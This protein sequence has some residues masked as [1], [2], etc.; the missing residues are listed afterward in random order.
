V[1]VDHA[2]V[3]PK[4]A[5]KVGWTVSALL[6]AAY[7]VVFAGYSAFSLQDYPN[8]LARAVAMSD[9]MFHGGA[10]F[11]ELFQYHFSAVPY[12]LGDL[13]L[14]GAI[15]LFGAR[16][17]SE[18][19]IALVM[20]SLPLALLFYLRGSRLAPDSRVLVFILS[21]YLS[22]DGFL[23]MGFLNFR[24]GVAMT[25]V[26]FAM[27]QILRQRW[28]TLLFAAYCVIVGLC[29]LMHLST[30]VFLGAAIGISALLRLWLRSTK[31]RNEAYFF[32]PVVAVLAWHFGVAIAHHAATDL[33]QNTFNWGTWSGKI[34]RLHWDF[35]RYYGTRL[36]RRVDEFLLLGFAV[37]LLWPIRH[38][39]G[40][41]AL[42]K[43]AVL[44]M[45]LLGMAFVGIYIVLPFTGSDVA[46]VDV[47]ALAL[48]PVFLML[49]CVYLRDENSTICGSEAPAT[50]ALAAVLAIGNLTYLTLH[51]VKDNAWMTRYREVIAAIPQDA[52]VL[53]LYP[54]TD[55]LRPFMHA[56][57]FVVI[58]RGAVIPYLFSGNRR[59]PQTYFRYIHMPYAPSESWYYEPAV[60][61][62]DIDWG[63]IACGYD[64][65]LVMKPFE[66]RRIRILVTP[67]MENESAA[68]LAVRKQGCTNSLAPPPASPGA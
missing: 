16:G 11:G 5:A 20:L 32:I 8:H 52:T 9:L 54:G 65:L 10:R 66:M 37:C 60:P 18:L 19:W 1:K 28:S 30:V 39:L 27:V 12:I 63:A 57:S 47:R 50:L 2:V 48:V 64:F 45:L 22:T 41:R 7:V 49:S 58:D 4:R 34:W 31:V 67:V 15:D 17:A 13:I 59:N 26:S 36:D 25:V 61:A 6:L 40:R 42:M 21:L 55:E 56:A 62:T 3:S 23:F 44:E 38:Q 46:Y 33:P 51:I 24:L 14:A 43:P 29:Y 53:P 35:M 68:L